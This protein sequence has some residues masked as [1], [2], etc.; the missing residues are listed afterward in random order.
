[1]EALEQLQEMAIVHPSAGEQAPATHRIDTGPSSSL[2]AVPD[3]RIT[4]LRPAQ[5]SDGKGLSV[6]PVY[7]LYPPNT[8]TVLQ[9]QGKGQRQAPLLLNL[10]VGLGEGGYGSPVGSSP[11]WSWLEKQSW[12]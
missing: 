3:P 11:C 5:A 7:R 8:H 6:R 1:M 10:G 9:I 4:G 2:K 12:F